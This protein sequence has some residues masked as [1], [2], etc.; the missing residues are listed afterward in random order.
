MNKIALIIVVTLIACGCNASPKELKLEVFD[1]DPSDIRF[2]A[3]F[4]EG[5]ELDG[6]HL[7]YENLGKR[8]LL[9]LKSSTGMRLTSAESNKSGNTITVSAFI[10][11][12]SSILTEVANRKEV[13]LNEIQLD[14]RL[15]SEVWN[16][17]VY[18]VKESAKTNSG[19]VMHKDKSTGFALLGAIQKSDLL[20]KTCTTLA[21]YS[22]ACDSTPIGIDPIAFQC[23]F[24][25]QDWD[26]IVGSVDAGI[27]EAM[28]FS[29][30]VATN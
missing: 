7:R 9:Q 17:S 10:E 14:L 3:T 28:S 11:L 6:I 25:N 21:K 1:S 26:E 20:V 13:S 29:I 12:V 30:V 22:Y 23:P 5:V 19:V 2:K 8:W 16:D 15:V 24:L 18:A 4:P 27:H